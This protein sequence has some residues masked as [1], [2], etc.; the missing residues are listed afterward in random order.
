[1]FRTLTTALMLLACTARTAAA[2]ADDQ[3]TEA[4]LGG[5]RTPSG[6]IYCQAF[7][8]GKARRTELRC[9]V[10]KN[11][12]PM[13]RRPADCEQDY[14]NA[15]NLTDGGRATRLCVGDTVADPELPVLAYGQTWSAK[16]IRCELTTLRLRCSNPAGRYF[17]LSRRAQRLG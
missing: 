14:G 1:M 3:T 5:F 8:I 2:Q 7:S 9:D 4:L 16:Q 10:L 6:N 13:V 11:D 12:A 17:A 15:F